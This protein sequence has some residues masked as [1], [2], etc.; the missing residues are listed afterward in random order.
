MEQRS[1][2]AI[3]SEICPHCS[4]AF[5]QQNS[6]N[7]HIRVVHQGRRPH[8]CECGKSFAT[9]EQLSRHINAKHTFQKP[10]VCER[11]CQK[12]FASYTARD[13]HHRV[14]HD[15][16]KCEC[17]VF[18]CN[19]RYSSMVHLKN[20]LSKPHNDNLLFLNLVYQF[21]LASCSYGFYPH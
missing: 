15:Q 17:P 10:F 14:V 19:K 11:G 4:K 21:F 18:G 6:L 7:R 8:T 16:L 9:R 2:E 5:K 1:N 13:Y 3:S 20:H 12:S